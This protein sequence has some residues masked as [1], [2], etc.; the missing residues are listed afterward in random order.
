MC[1]TGVCTV[2]QVRMSNLVIQLCSNSILYGLGC[3]SL[4][5]NGG[6][7]FCCVED[8]CN[9]AENFWEFRANLSATTTNSVGQQIFSTDNLISE[10]SW[11]PT[12]SPT[13]KIIL[14]YMSSGMFLL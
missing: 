10:T 13:G 7:T 1:T 2:Q 5:H 14:F 3:A 9:S 4:N 8:Y 12:A 6:N 11:I